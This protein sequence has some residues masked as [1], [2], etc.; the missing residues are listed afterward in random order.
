MTYT[1]I[2]N[3]EDKKCC[4][5]MIHDAMD[6]Y[7]E[8]NKHNIPC[9]DERLLAWRMMEAVL[10]RM[11]VSTRRKFHMREYCDRI[12]SRLLNI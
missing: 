6:A 4:K 9:Y 1:V 3:E 2:T 7:C 8:Y 10:E 12:M 5:R 11:P